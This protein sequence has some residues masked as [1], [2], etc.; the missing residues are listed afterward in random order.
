MFSS[1][2]DRG[3][4]SKSVEK[5]SGSKKKWERATGLQKSI[6]AIEQE[7]A[8]LS[9]Q[10][11]P[12]LSEV[13]DPRLAYTLKQCTGIDSGKRDAGKVEKILSHYKRNRPQAIIFQNWDDMGTLASA[14]SV[15]TG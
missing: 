1:K 6:Q 12:S 10:V 7:K 3:S 8:R 14:A 13:F 15:F 9:S 2:K 4:S 5:A 11:E